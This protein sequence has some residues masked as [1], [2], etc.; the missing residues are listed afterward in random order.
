MELWP[1]ISEAEL[2]GLGWSL[3]VSDR[4]PELWER[5]RDVPGF[6]WSAVG[7]LDPEVDPLE[8]DDHAVRLAK[9]QQSPEVENASWTSAGERSRP[10]PCFHE[11]NA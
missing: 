9:R 1:D 3:L 11:S 2:V 4:E 5:S 6:R 7:L 10:N 8:W